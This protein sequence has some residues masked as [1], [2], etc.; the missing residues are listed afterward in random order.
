MLMA[1]KGRFSRH[2][3]LFFTILQAKIIQVTL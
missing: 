2:L 1:K 3:V